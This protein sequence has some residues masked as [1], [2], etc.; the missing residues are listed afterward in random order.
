VPDAFYQLVLPSQQVTWL[1]L[2]VDL[3]TMVISPSKWQ[4]RAWRRKFLAYRGL[5]ESGVLKTHYGADAM[6]VTIV[7]TSPARA[8]NLVKACERAGG[9]AR[10][11]FTTFNELKTD[12]FGEIW[13]VA[14]KGETLYRLLPRR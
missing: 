1:F 12:L 3:A 14:G 7:T 4:L 9:D 10:F 13:R 8:A 6:I 11:W 5:L 2:E